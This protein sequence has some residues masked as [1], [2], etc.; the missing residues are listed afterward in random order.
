[1]LEGIKMSQSLMN[2][3]SGSKKKVNVLGLCLKAALAIAA[4][5]VILVLTLQLSESM[6]M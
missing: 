2:P 6:M 3:V 5:A 4:V 1:M